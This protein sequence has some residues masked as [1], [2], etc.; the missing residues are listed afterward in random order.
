[1]PLAPPARCGRRSSPRLVSACPHGCTGHVL[2]VYTIASY[3]YIKS[4]GGA[5]RGPHAGP[6]APPAACGRR[7]RPAPRPRLVPT[8]PKFCTGHVLYE[9]KI[10]SCMYIKSAR[11]P[12]APLLAP[13]AACGRRSRP[14]PR[15]RLVPTCPKV[16]T[17]HVLYVYKIAIPSGCVRSIFK[18]HSGRGPRAVPVAPPATCVHVRLDIVSRQNAGLSLSRE[19]R[20]NPR[21]VVRTIT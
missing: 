2:Y 16:C 3:I 12:R 13:P 15:P 18:Q 14:A 6:L 11:G 17:G 20:I 8:C 21:V 19:G 9:Y 10:A 5:G 7:S 4:G 1:M